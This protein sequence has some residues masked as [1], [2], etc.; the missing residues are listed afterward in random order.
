[1]T[2]SATY[3]FAKI[4]YLLLVV[5]FKLNTFVDSADRIWRLPSKQTSFTR[6]TPYVKLSSGAQPKVPVTSIDRPKPA[7]VSSCPAERPTG[8]V[9]LDPSTASSSPVQSISEL[10]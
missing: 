8:E 10:I 3:N 6:Y 1:M 9:P 2:P 4:L 5:E 7:V